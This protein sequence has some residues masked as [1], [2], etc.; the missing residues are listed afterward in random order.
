MLVVD[1]VVEIVV[2]AGADV[3]VVVTAVVVGGVVGS[4]EDPQPDKYRSESTIPA[5]ALMASRLS[6][7][8]VI[9]TG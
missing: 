3:V 8:E 7:R 2:D 5:L 6:A 9:L 4:V 1:E